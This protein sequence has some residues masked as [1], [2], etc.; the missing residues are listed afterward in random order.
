MNEQAIGAEVL[1]RIRVLWGYRKWYATH[2]GWLVEERVDNIR[3]LRYLIAL[4]RK[5]RR[6]SEQADPVTAAKAYHDWQSE[7]ELYVPNVE[8]QPE[9]NGAFR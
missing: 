3:E 8:G 9:F 2:T 5:A 6:E 4:V 7:P 1:D